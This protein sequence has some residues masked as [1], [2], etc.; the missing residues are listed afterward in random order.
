MD[1]RR[2]RRWL[3]LAFAAILLVLTPFT[4]MVHAQENTYNMEL[5]NS[6]L[7]EDGV[8]TVGMEANYAPF[9]WSQTSLLMALLKLVT[10]L[11]S[12]PMVMTY[13]WLFYSLKSL[14][15]N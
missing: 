3:G 13:K 5:I 10:H 8:L 4:T 11:V 7:D 15:Y 1:K 12:M 6:G 9:N 14:V 2:V